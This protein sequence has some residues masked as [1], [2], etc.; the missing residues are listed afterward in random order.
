MAVSFKNQSFQPIYGKQGTG[1]L[2]SQQQLRTDILKL[3]QKDPYMAAGWALGTALGNDYWGRKRA[4]SAAEAVQATD[5]NY[6]STGNAI[7]DQMQGGQQA[8]A[9]ADAGGMLG[10]IAQ[11]VMAPAGSEVNGATVPQTPQQQQKTPVTFENAGEGGGVPSVQEAWDKMADS[12]TYDKGNTGL[13]TNGIRDIANVIGGSE[14]QAPALPVN[15]V[16]LQAQEAPA[17]VTQIVQQAAAQ[18]FSAQRRMDDAINY[19]MTKK[20]YNYDDAAALMTPYMNSWKQREEDETKALAN[21]LMSQLNSGQLSDGDYKQRLVQLAQLGDYGRTAA[22]VYGSDMVSGREKWLA[23][24]RA[25]S[26]NRRFAQQQAIAQQNAQNRLALAQQM[27]QARQNMKGNT[28]GSSGSRTTKSP[29]ASEEFKYMAN[30]LKEIGDIPAEQR[31]AEQNQFF[32][33]YKPIHDSIINQSL[34]NSFSAYGVGKNQPSRPAAGTFNPNDY[35]QAVQKFQ[36]L[37]KSGKYNRGDVESFI[38]QKYGLK[39]DDKSNQFVEDLI[40][41]IQW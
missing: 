21:D 30:N 38:R 2:P 36:A 16:P 32:N 23:Q 6:Y 34:G 17:G 20:G 1:S 25:D 24:Q 35:N 29:L 9:T 41:G 28:F 33:T 14:Q 22:N 40:N 26:E 12:V 15:N 19:L 13:F 18:P 4:K 39:P 10:Q 37:A 8:P 27:Q 5:P 7:L 31:T 11:G 3:M